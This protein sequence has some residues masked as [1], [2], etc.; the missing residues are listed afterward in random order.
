MKRQM[1][2]A[3]LDAFKSF[4]NFGFYDVTIGTWVLHYNHHF[5]EHEKEI[6]F[7]KL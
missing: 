1:F 6:I 2:L 3:S 4:T 5:K 7:H